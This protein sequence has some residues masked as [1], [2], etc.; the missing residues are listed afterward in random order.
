MN[1][2]MGNINI[3][4][5]GLGTSC[6]FP[7]CQLP[8]KLAWPQLP[9]LCQLLWS[10]P[11]GWQGWG[12]H[13][14]SAGTGKWGW[15]RTAWQRLAWRMGGRVCWAGQCPREAGG[16]CCGSIRKEVG[17]EERRK[18][19]E[20]EGRKEEEEGG[21]EWQEKSQDGAKVDLGLNPSPAT[22]GHVNPGRVT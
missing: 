17:N 5:E 19:R 6:N 1:Y 15:W 10:E 9:G 16:G 3:I 7:K 13:T 18:G 12:W 2:D 21:K 11:A 4:G 22:Y 8:S 20:N 14:L